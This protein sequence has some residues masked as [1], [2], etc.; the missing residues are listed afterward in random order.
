MNVSVVVPTFNGSTK[1]SVLLEALL[2]QTETRFELVVV[3]DGSMDNTIEVVKR[4]EG[5]FDNFKLISQN[6]GG[7]SVVRNRAANEASGNLLI[8]YDDDMEPGPDSVK[9]HVEF[10][11]THSG[12]LSGNQ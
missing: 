12:I 2:Q 9:Q 1:I 3:D 10:H 8:F 4:Y 5:R 7:R 6:N 11:Q